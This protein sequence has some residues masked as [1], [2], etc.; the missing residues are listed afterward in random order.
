MSANER[1]DGVDCGVTDSA[2]PTTA[3]QIPGIRRAMRRARRHHAP[4]LG[5]LPGAPIRAMVLGYG[6]TIH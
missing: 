3:N 5:D 6:L 4:H 2:I 1:N